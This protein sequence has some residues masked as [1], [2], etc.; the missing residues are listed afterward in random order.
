MLHRALLLSPI[1]L[2]AA[3]G[4][5]W[6]PADP[7]HGSAFE[8]FEADGNRMENFVVGGDATSPLADYLFVVD[9]STSMAHILNRFE[10]GV[11]TLSE[12][13]VFPERARIAVMNTTPADPADSSQPH[14][15]VSGKRQAAK[16]PGFMGLVDSDKLAAYTRAFPKLQEVLPE[17]GCSAWFAPG[18]TNSNGVPCLVA[19]AQV[20]LQGVVAEAGL[21]AFK[22]LV[23]N[24]EGSLFRGGA[25]V[26]VIFISDTHDPGVPSVRAN[27]KVNRL[28]R[29]IGSQQLLAARPDFAELEA[30]VQSTQPVASFRVHAIAP[31]SE[32]AEPWA[33]FGPSYFEAAAAAKG[34]QLDVCT[35]LDYAPFLRST[36]S[37]GA[38]A[39][40][41]VL[42]LGR[43]ADSVTSVTVDEVEAPFSV[44]RGAVVL[45]QGLPVEPT[46][47]SITYRPR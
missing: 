40:A 44:D 28:D 29:I 5:D 27:G 24:H 25:N 34:Q 9:G 6:Q 8:A 35:A 7:G 12:A 39:T 47:V 4:P 38:V 43:P 3:C 46:P 18:E 26:N 14:P 11:R 33:E 23:E 37:E 13:G 21:T 1:L 31:M 41:P 16:A 22:Q 20:D 15:V 30:L 36:I 10:E 42:A 17:P 45:E 2:L 32:C 19:H